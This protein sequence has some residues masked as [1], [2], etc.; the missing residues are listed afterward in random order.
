[1]R[2]AILHSLEYF[3]GKLRKYKLRMDANIYLLEEN[4]DRKTGGEAAP[5]L[6][7]SKRISSHSIVLH[8]SQNLYDTKIEN[9]TLQ[10]KESRCIMRRKNRDSM[11]D[12]DSMRTSSSDEEM[13]KLKKMRKSTLNKSKVKASI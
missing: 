3:N 7:T 8:P 4:A 1:M 10:L 6:Q 9:F 2:E 13:A 5:E 11:D 12:S